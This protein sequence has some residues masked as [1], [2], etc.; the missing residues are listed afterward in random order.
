M[1]VDDD[2]SGGALGSVG[3]AAHQRG[4]AGAVRTD[5]ADQLARMS[6]EVDAVEDF[7]AAEAFLHPEIIRA[8]PVRPPRLEHAR[9]DG[10]QAHRSAVARVARRATRRHSHDAADETSAAGHAEMRR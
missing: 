7:Q 6:L 1:T 10:N 9:R 3:D 5:E 8:G 2:G 4:L